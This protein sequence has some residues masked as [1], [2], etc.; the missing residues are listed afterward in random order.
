MW[1]NLVNYRSRA[2]C[3]VLDNIVYGFI[4]LAFNW[5]LSQ[6]SLVFGG[7][8]YEEYWP[9][10]AKASVERFD[11]RVGEWEDVAPML[12]SR[13]S[14]GAAF[15][16]GEVYVVGGWNHRRTQLRTVEM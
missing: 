2:A 12:L 6:I 16:N 1:S 15:L 4:F 5:L 9:L 11:P 14:A 7:G 13:L 8:N 10:T 3:C